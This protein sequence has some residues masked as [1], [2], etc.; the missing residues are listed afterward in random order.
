MNP[1]PCGFWGDPQ[2]ACR[3]TPDQIK[4]YT[5]RISGPL[6]D[7]ID[8][9]ITLSRLPAST[10]L[11]QHQGGECSSAVRSRV[12]HCTHTQVQRQGY[13]NALLPAPE[14]LKICA[15]G[16]SESQY[17]EKAA[18][19]MQLSARALHRSLRVGRTIADMAGASRLSVAHLNEALG[20][21]PQEPNH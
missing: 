17:L 4:R 8:L 13:R 1:C 14:L 21:R 18:D 10:L 12:E 3:C 20:Y 15:L 6:L 7:R 19:S 2:R 11:G 5:G 16:K 9:H